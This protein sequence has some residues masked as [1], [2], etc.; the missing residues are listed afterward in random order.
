[1]PFDANAGSS[2]G[3]K[4]AV[5]FSKCGGDPSSTAG[6]SATYTHYPNW[7][8]ASEC[9]IYEMALP[10]GA[11]KLVAAIHDAGASDA[12]PAIW[13]GNI[14]FSRVR[15]G[16]KIA[17]IYLWQHAGDRLVRLGGGVDRRHPV[18]AIPSKAPVEAWAGRMSLDGD[19]LAFEWSNTI[20]PAFR[21]HEIRVDPLY[22]LRQDA[23]SQ[24]AETSWGGGESCGRWYSSQS[25][26]ASGDSVLLTNMEGECEQLTASTVGVFSSSVDR[27]DSFALEKSIVVALAQD[28][29]KTYWIADSPAPGIPAQRCLETIACASAGNRARIESCAP[30]SSSCELMMSTGLPLAVKGR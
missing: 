15:Q 12:T 27:L 14:A 4:P 13:R 26:S 6:S 21:E 20:E 17:E 9:R 10:S 28:H 25:P 2:V 24:V 18:Y 1:M 19:L 29:A 30:A 22:D 7:I 23:P 11:P 16:A 5:V 3:G 8:E